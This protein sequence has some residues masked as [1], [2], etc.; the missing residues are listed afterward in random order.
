MFNKENK[1][2][3]MIL[4]III[5]LYFNNFL[6]GLEAKCI[7]DNN[8]NCAKIGK[9]YAFSVYNNGINL[10]KFSDTIELFGFENNSPIYYSY[11]FCD[12][13]KCEKSTRNVNFGSY[14]VINNGEYYL[15]QSDNGITVTKDFNKATIFE[16]KK[17]INENIFFLKSNIGCIGCCSQLSD[18][19]R[20]LLSISH[21]DCLKLQLKDF[22]IT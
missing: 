18:S 7:I 11:K 13:K 6:K 16:L 8:G 15:L 14:Y 10:F 21:N 20:L 12:T 2:I 9:I 19:N 3:N 22:F 5:L 1:K 17:E 4:N